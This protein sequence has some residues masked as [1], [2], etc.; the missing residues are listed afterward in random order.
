VL[1]STSQY[2]MRG[3]FSGSISDQFPEIGFHG[4]KALTDE[5]GET[6]C[7]FGTPGLEYVFDQDCRVPSLFV[8]ILKKQISDDPAFR[9]FK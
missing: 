2:G 5:S 1:N 9:Y 6:S 8:N 4:L 3:H 7:G